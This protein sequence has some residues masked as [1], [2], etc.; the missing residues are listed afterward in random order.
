MNQRELTQLYFKGVK[1]RYLKEYDEAYRVFLQCAEAGFAHAMAAVG[2]C[3]Y[4]GWG[5]E[6]D[7]DKAREWA[8]TSLDAGNDSAK[9][10]LEIC[11]SFRDEQGSS[12][13]AV[14]A[15]PQTAEEFYGY[16]LDY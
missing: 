12:A 14:R 3:Y 7:V 4:N 6:R 11:D 9:S 15:Q 10:L 5:V 13:K 8:Q 1:L 16:G 2:S